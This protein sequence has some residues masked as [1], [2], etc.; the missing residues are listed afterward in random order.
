M[1]DPNI[2][3]LAQVHM[4]REQTLK[5]RGLLAEHLEENPTKKIKA[6]ALQDQLRHLF[7][8]YND[9][10]LSQIVGAV[11]LSNIVHAV[12]TLRLKKANEE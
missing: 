12:A 2:V 4:A 6:E 10:E 7:Q 11:V 9:D 1:I 8:S 3:L 5:A